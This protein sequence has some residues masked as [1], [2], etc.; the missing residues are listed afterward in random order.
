MNAWYHAQSSARKW[1]GSPDAYLPVHECIDSSKEAFP[2]M[3]HRAMLHSSWGIY[4]AGRMFGPTLTVP[5]KHGEVPVPVRLIAEQHVLED[6]GRIPTI[7]DYLQ[8]MTLQPWM[9]GAR[10]RTVTMTDF[11]GAP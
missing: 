11:V 1:G 5:R 6:L 8:H 7:E 2:D 9:G 4:L 10:R 3:R